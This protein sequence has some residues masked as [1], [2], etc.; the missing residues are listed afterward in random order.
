MCDCAE[1]SKS[2]IPHL[3]AYSA[4]KGRYADGCS[5]DRRLLLR[6]G[7]DAA[8]VND[9]SICGAIVHRLAAVGCDNETCDVEREAADQNSTDIGTSNV[10]VEAACVEQVLIADPGQQTQRAHGRGGGDEPNA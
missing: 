2:A 9:K 8:I 1:S 3:C 5:L 6:P 10:S 4:A 7:K